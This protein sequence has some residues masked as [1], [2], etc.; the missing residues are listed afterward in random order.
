MI[1]I[2]NIK[3][4][5]HVIIQPTDQTITNQFIKTIKKDHA[6]IHRIEI[7]VLT[8]DKKNYSQSAHRNNTRYQNSQQN[9]RSSTPKHQKQM[10]QVQTTEEIQP[11]PPGNDN[12][13]DTELNHINYES[14]DSKS[15]TEIT[16]SI[17]MINVENDYEPIIYKK[18]IY[19]H[20]YKN[21]DHLLLNYYTR[22]ITSNKTK[23]KIEKTE[24]EVTE[25]KPT[26]C[27]STKY[28]YQNNSIEPQYKKENSG[29][30]HF[31]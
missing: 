3:E 9:Y 30:S 16:I 24:E 2:L 8:I 22:P 17:N 26:E 27:S 31:F 14:T 13:G 25:E 28:N 29:Q 5:D 15:D 10:N 12:N 21:H 18:P 11:D 20:I 19:S 23:E 6:I 7:Q 4:L 1:E